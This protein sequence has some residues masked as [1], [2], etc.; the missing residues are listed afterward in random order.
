MDQLTSEDL[1]QA[2][3]ILCIQPHYDD[4]DIGAGGTLAALAKSGVE[5]DY[6]TV[7]DD[8]VG[9]LDI[10]VPVDR[11]AEILKQEQVEAGQV[12][13]VNKQ[14][15]LGYPDGGDFNYFELRRNVIQYI[16]M[17]KPDYI[18][19]VDP[20]L[21]YEAHFD[22]IRTGRAAAEAAIMYHFM[23]IATKEE[24][25]RSYQPYLLKGIVFYL[26]NL[27]NLVFDISDSKELKNRA[28]RSYRSQ[29]NEE[30]MKAALAKIDQ[31]DQDAGKE[32]GYLYSETLKFVKTENLHIN[33]D[34]W[35]P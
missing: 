25:D 1:Y 15:W 5:I 14:F 34:N 28:I 22:H 18:F 6:L 26:T 13:G 32:K 31:K 20:W 8:L 10:S 17:L 4:N 29:F 30:E 3:R 35:V 21:L 9:F 19:T 23:R 33:T 27:P 7:T 2:K 11:A 16:R 24:V 12:I